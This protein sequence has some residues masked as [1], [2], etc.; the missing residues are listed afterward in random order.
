MNRTKKQYGRVIAVMA[1]LSIALTGCQ[2]GGTDDAGGGDGNFSVTFIPMRLGDPYFDQSDAAGIAVAEELGGEGERVGPSQ[3]TPDS[4]V[5]FI[6]TA[7]QQGRS[8][9]MIASNDPDAICD[10]VDEARDAGA[11]VLTYDADSNPECRDLYIQMASAEEVARTHIQLISDQIGEG[12]G[13]IAILSGTAN[14]ALHNNWIDLMK[15]DLASD[16]PDLEL[17]ETVY[18]NEDDQKSFDETAALLQKYPDLKG[19]VAPT[20]V[21]LV[22]AARYLSNSPL[23]GE[24]KLTGL[25][26]P[27]E[28]RPYVK[29]GTS[30]SFLLWVPADLG[31]LATYAAHAIVSGEIEAKEGE[32]FEAGYLGSYTVEKDNV[33][34][35]G[36]PQIF[37]AENI[38]DFDF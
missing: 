2:G 12:G 29:D 1:V 31:A 9:I 21:G 32:T 3:A 8:A 7:A 34:V 28:M 17:V 5:P 20:T 11:T 36:D 35:L 37:N 24:V 15:K 10:A 38:D 33:V 27:N 22:A 6:N 23:K 13:Q 19:I 30:E 26:T 4:Q 25:G 16:F 18:G 14:S